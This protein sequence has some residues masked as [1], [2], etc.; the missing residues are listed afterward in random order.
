MGLPNINIEFIAKGATAI[1]RSGRGVV[2]CIMA[3]ATEGGAAFATYTSV[4]DVDF[5]KYTEQNY[6][7]L[8]M[9]F[10][11]A[12]SKVHVVRVAAKTPDYTA[13]LKVLKDIKFNY[14]TIPSID[15]EG[16]TV[17]TAWIKEQRDQYKK[18]FKAILPNIKADHEGIINFTTGGIVSSFSQ[19]TLTAAQYCP[20]IAGVLAG[21]TLDRSAT[22][23]KLTDISAADTPDD[24]DARIDAG[25]LI[26]VYDGD[27]YKLGRA[28]NS[29][30]T[31]TGDK[32]ADLAK[33]KI[34]E[35]MD[36]YRD[37]IRQTFE[38]RYVGNYINDY[39][40][41]QLFVAAVGSYIKQLEGNVLD[42]SY[43]NTAVV[44]VEAQRTYLESSGTD[45][46]N[47]ADI[48]IA[49]ANT[50]SRVFVRSNIKFVDA[51]EDMDMVVDM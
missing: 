9:I 25:E 46:T 4:A 6:T 16:V 51:M 26:V 31:F 11:G 35:G 50:G 1:V 24:P 44:D 33:I 8:Q 18:T 34:V 41:K 39:D 19:Q 10:A 5:T 38:D 20:R 21:L 27:S 28:V 12:P 23:Y 22:Y 13:A 14:L 30:T 3:D 36:L 15:E 29:L 32:R 40:N 43:D 49:K 37:D 48:D 42:R 7:Y 45:T 2:A 17:V 47:M